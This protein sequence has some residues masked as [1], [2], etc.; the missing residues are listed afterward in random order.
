VSF[1][2]VKVGELQANGL[3]DCLKE[4]NAANPIVAQ[5]NG[6]PSDNNARLFKT[7]YDAPLN[8]TYDAAQM[9]KGPEQWVPDWDPDQAAVIFEQ[10]LTQ[11]PGIRGVLSANDGIAGSVIK[12]LRKHNLSGVV[13]VTGQDATL[14]ALQNIL[15]GEQCMTVY[16]AIKPQAL[17][18]A[19]LAGELFNGGKP[20]IDDTVK[21]S[22]SGAYVPF[23]KLEPT[24]ITLRNINTVVV[25]DKFVLQGDL[26]KGK[27]L[28]DCKTNG[29]GTFKKPKPTDD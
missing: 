18:A 3:I 21:D 1:D 29:V 28:A 23:V 6:S 19:K 15:T 12:V 16:K 5:L 24:P 11:S 17:S 2:N 10:M 27:Y 13:P 26:C 8:K 9:R 20:K 4:R 7:G 22:E 14:E 25:Q